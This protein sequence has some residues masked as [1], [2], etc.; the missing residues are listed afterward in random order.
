LMRRDLHTGRRVVDRTLT[1]VQVDRQH[2]DIAWP[3]G[4][5]PSGE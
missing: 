2:F 1:H 3:L 5:Q 4:R